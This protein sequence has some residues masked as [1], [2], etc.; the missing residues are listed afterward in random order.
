MSTESV[1]ILYNR[2]DPA[3]AA[4]GG[5]QESDAGILKEVEAVR[6][7]LRELGWPAREAGIR[8]LDEMPGVLADGDESVVFNLVERLEGCET[9]FNFVPAVCGMLGRPCTGN[10]ADTLMLSFDK[11]LSKC[12]LRQAGLA[13]PEGVVWMP[14]T[15]A[16]ALPNPPM[17]VKPVRTD[18]S[19]GI[20]VAS[21]LRGADADMVRQTVGRIHAGFRQAALI[22][23]FIEGRELNVSVMERD[24][25]PLVLP[26]SEV[27]F[28]LY[29]PGRPHI[30]DYDVKWHP[31]V[32]AG[33]QSP[34][35]VPAPLDATTQRRAEEAGCRAWKAFRCRGYAR[36]DFRLGTDGQLYILEVN[37][38]PDISPMAGFPASLK[39]A[40][41][42]FPAFI[43]AMV[44]GATGSRCGWGK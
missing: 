35:R 36:F 42:P 41:I 30:V 44:A 2:P 6:D 32:L 1:L 12:C 29:P 16:P 15:P 5:W 25:E 13:V 7:A 26:I 27:D 23:R 21:V 11:W 34:R 33:I 37:A 18:G 28:S 40:G 10:D 14:G 39:A 3:T 8:S 24:G 43:A 4:A 22:E 9:D 17:I 31:G 38:N 19:E 20:S